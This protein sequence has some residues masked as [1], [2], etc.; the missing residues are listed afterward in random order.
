MLL[1]KKWQIFSNPPSPEEI[2]IVLDLSPSSSWILIII[3]EQ[4]RRKRWFALH[5]Q[6]VIG[7]ESLQIIWVVRYWCHRSFRMAFTSHK[8][9]CRTSSSISCSLETTEKN[10]LNGP[11]QAFPFSTMMRSKWRI[12]HP[13]TVIIAESSGFLHDLVLSVLP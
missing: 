1:L 10:I 2:S 7:R 12:E 11:Y 5:K 3:F 8:A 9:V 4:S 6:Q 13:F